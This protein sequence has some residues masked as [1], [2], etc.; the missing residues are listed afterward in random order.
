MG[1]MGSAGNVDGPRALRVNEW[2]QLDHVVST[3]FR[4]SMFHDYPQLFAQS[5]RETL[6]V[7]AEGGR[8]VCHVGMIERPASLVGCRIDVCCIGAVAT[9]DEARGRG[10]ASLAFQDACDKAAAD[11]VDVMLISG[12]RGLYTRVGCRQVGQD[13]DFSLTESELGRLASVRPPGGGDFAVAPIGPERIPEL[14]ALYAAEGVRFLRRRE[15]WEMAFACGVVMNTPSHFWG[16][17]LGETLVAYLIVHDPARPR[18]RAPDE[19]ASVR[20]VEF[21]GVRASVIAALPRLRVHYGVERLTLHAQGSDP[22]LGRVLRA[23]T[24]A[25]GTPSGASGTIRIINFV[26]LM[27][28][29]RPL[30]AERMGHA[31]SAGLTFHASA[32]PGTAE[33]SFAIRCGAEEVRIDS[34]SSL[35]LFLFGSHR[36]IAAPDTEPQGDAALLASLRDAL[37]LPSLWYG[38]SYV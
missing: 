9:L 28:R 18:R 12:G 35:A 7:V 37:P 34:L 24:G 11:G 27:E 38:V 26:Q 33:G 10:Y 6:R 16:V 29:C 22:V 3:V 36:A 15:D 4:P 2:D 13:L 25:A 32:A 31:A 20:V 21:A 14:S 30:L 17:T 23:A 5:N 19:P 1:S 8:V